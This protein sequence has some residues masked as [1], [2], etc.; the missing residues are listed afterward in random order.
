MTYDPNPDREP[1][2]A[3]SILITLL[4]WLLMLLGLVLLAGGIWLIQLGGSWY[5]A[6]AGLGLLLSGF[7]LT[8]RLMAA[9]FVYCAVWFGTVIWAFYEVGFDWWGHVPRLVAPTVLLIAILLTL[10][11]LRFMRED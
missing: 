1:S 2:A 8:R 3:A 10:P 7:S 11:A 6:I 5:Y 4:A 9:V